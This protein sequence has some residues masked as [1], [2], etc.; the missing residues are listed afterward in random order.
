MYWEI[1]PPR[2][3]RF[4]EGGDFAS[5]GPRDC[6]R[7]KFCTPRVKGCKT[8]PEGNLEAV[9]DH[10]LSISREVLLLWCIFHTKNIGL[11]FCLYFLRFVRFV[12]FL[13]RSYT[14]YRPV[15]F[16]DKMSSCGVTLGPIQT[17]Y[18]QQLTFCLPENVYIVPICISTGALSMGVY[19]G[20]SVPRPVFPNT[21][22]RTRERI[23]KIWS[24]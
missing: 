11:R 24:L 13:R 16:L 17:F 4:P 7:T 14:S 5:R 3:E 12:D 21:L 6:P 23:G 10:S 22:P 18:K 2:T 8:L 15:I 20:N 19:Q 9:Y 1:H